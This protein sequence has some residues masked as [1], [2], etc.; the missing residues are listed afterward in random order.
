MRSDGRQ[1]H[2]Q[3]LPRNLPTVDTLR[4]LAEQTDDEEFEDD[5]DYDGA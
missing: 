5:Y 1:H 2:R 4:F 3:K